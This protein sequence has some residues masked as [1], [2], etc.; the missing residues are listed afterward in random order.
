MPLKLAHFDNPDGPKGQVAVLNKWADWVETQLHATQS[1]IFKVANTAVTNIPATPAATTSVGDSLTHGDPIWWVDSA[2]VTLRD[3]FNNPPSTNSSP[4]AVAFGNGLIWDIGASGA[5]SNFPGGPFPLNG[6]IGFC[7][8]SA[9]AG[10]SFVRLHSGESAG[11]NGYPLLDYPGWKMVWVFQIMRNGSPTPPAFS[12]TKVSL[13]AGLSNYVNG[14]L[15]TSSSPRPPYFL[16][17]RYDT[18]TTSPAISDTQ[19]VFEYVTNFTASPTARI[20]TQGT[21]FATGITPVEGRIYR[22]EI[23]CV[24]SGQ[25][26]MF[27][28]DGVTSVSTTLNVSQFSFSGNQP[29]FTTTN[30][31]VLVLWTSGTSLPLDFGTKVTISG[32]SI[33]NGNGTFTNNAL[34]GGVTG[35]MDF[36]SAITISGSD[37]GATTSFYPALTPFFAFGNDTEASPTANSKGVYVDLMALVWNKGLITGGAKTNSLLARYY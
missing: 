31:I 24:A 8:S 36:L 11:G 20:N 17:L 12:W 5:F 27:L 28:T 14:S 22:L 16:G 9:S 2:W 37:T 32:G 33:A 15:S 6:A 25:V 10:I 7:N 1:K 3:D 35:E 21:T 13:Y 23:S 29:S 34:R 30:G 26:L 19:F 4:T 18:D